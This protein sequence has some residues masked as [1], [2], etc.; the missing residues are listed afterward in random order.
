MRPCV[1]NVWDLA[2]NK[3]SEYW[4][5]GHLCGFFFHD[6]TGDGLPELLAV[7][8]RNQWGG[9]VLVALDPF[10]MSGQCPPLPGEAPVND[11]MPIGGELAYVLFPHSDFVDMGSR[12]VSYLVTPVGD[13]LAVAVSN[14]VI[15]PDQ[16]LFYSDIVAYT[17]TKDFVPLGVRFGDAYGERLRRVSGRPDIQMK[18]RTGLVIRV[19][20]QGTW[21]DRVVP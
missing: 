16:K 1:V 20:R 14:P 21:E 2:G 5:W 10:M 9:A 15:T 4:H 3:L 18:P 13:R 7:G 11:S 17:L 6:I 12:D 8:V 19:W